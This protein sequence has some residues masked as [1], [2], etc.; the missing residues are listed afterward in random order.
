M[1]FGRVHANFYGELL[2]I[3]PELSPSEIRI[4]ALLRLNLSTKEMEALTFKSES[5]IKSIR[6]RLRKKL[7][8]DSDDNLTAFLIR[9]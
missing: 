3:C 6:Y 1:A 5:G 9:I 4:A 7:G 8:L 2:R